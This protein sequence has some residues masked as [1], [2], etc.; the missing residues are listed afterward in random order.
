MIRPSSS[1]RGPKGSPAA[2]EPQRV[3]TPP[4][5]LLGDRPKDLIQN[6]AGW[7]SPLLVL[8][9]HVPMPGPGILLLEPAD[10]CLLSPPIGSRAPSSG[11][12]TGSVQRQ[13]T[14]FQESLFWQDVK[15]GRWK[16]QI[17][18]EEQI[19]IWQIQLPL[20]ELVV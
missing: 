7:H 8:W 1:A 13:H 10:R 2:K 11:R 15:R 4:R 12:S 14:G 18:F 17:D 6:M 19:V 9:I 16:E 3:C 5:A 20:G